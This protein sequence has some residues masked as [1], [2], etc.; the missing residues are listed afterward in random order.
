MKYTKKQKDFIRKC[1]NHA[2]NI[3]LLNSYGRTWRW[4]EAGNAG[5]SCNVAATMET[6]LKYKEL[7]ISI[8]P[9]F[10]EETEYK[11]FEIIFHEFCHVITEHQYMISVHLRE[12][13]LVT[14]REIEFA[15]EHE[16]SLMEK[17]FI[18]MLGDLKQYK[19]TSDFIKSLS[20]EKRNK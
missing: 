16:T 6:D 8:Y 17:A 14:A 15:R 4:Y 18:W 9:G 5:K 10:L 12:D 3:L 2:C 11:Q 19:E 13:K 20:V 1:A 7:E